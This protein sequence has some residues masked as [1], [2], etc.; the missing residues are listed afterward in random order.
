MPILLAA[1][2]LEEEQDHFVA[3]SSLNSTTYPVFVAL[4]LESEKF[5]LK[6]LMP[7]T[8]KPPK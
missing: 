1:M 2:S 7:M 6:N 3:L 5:S 8:P 4:V